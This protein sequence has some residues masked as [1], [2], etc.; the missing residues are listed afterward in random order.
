M[1]WLLSRGTHSERFDF[2]IRGAAHKF[3]QSNDWYSV[4]SENEYS[5]SGEFRSLCQ[6]GEVGHKRKLLALT[7]HNCDL[8]SDGCRDIFHD[9]ATSLRQNDGT[10]Q[11]RYPLPGCNKR[12]GGMHLSGL[13]NDVRCESEGRAYGDR[14]IEEPR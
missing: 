1:V 13:L 14:L 7:C 8:G 11:Y 2:F 10:R 5:R 3:V 4:I 6:R 9:D 12:D